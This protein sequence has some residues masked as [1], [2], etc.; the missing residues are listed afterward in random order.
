MPKAITI[1]VT[2]PMSETVT[3]RHRTVSGAAR[4]LAF[5]DREAADV[6]A[7]WGSGVYSVDVEVDG[8]R[9]SD[10]ALSICDGDYASALRDAA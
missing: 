1:T 2:A 10:Q 6:H 9:V 4:R 7:A 8:R 5:L 3:T